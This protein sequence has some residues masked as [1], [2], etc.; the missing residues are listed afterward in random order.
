MTVDMQHAGERVQG[1]AAEAAGSASVLAYLRAVVAASERLV[2]ETG[3][4]RGVDAALEALRLDTGLDRVYVFRDAPGSDGMFIYSE[5]SHPRVPGIQALFGDRHFPDDQYPEVS[6]PLRAGRI[7]QSVHTQRH[8][9][10]A[11]YNEAL[12]SRSDLMVPIVV[13]GR[14]WGAIGF[15]DCRSD[16]VWNPSEIA[17]LQGAASAIAAAVL[18]D[19]ADRAQARTAADLAMRDRLLAAVALALQALLGSDDGHFADA[20]HAT[21]AALGAACGIHRIKVILQRPA[22]EDGEPTHFLDHE[23]WSAGMASQT[24]LGLT[25][26]PNTLVAEWVAILQRGEASWYL[27]EDVPMAVRAA[28]ARVGVRSVGSVPVFGGGQYL[29]L[30]AFDDCVHRRVWSDAEID[31]LTAAARTIGSAIH[32]HSLQQAMLAERDR[33]VEVEQARAEESAR[34]ALRSGRHADLLAAV[35]SAAADLLAEREPGACLDAVLARI[36]QVTQAERA[37]VARLDWTP[38]D[39]CLLGWQ[40]IAHEWARPGSRRQM[41]SDLRR[42]AMQRSDGTWERGLTQFATESRILVKIGDQDEPFRSQQ[43]A[44]GIVWS[45][46]YPI[47]V[48]G[49]VW[50]LLGFDYATSFGEYDEADLAALQTVASNIAAALLRQQLERRA[51]DAVRARAEELARLAERVDRHAQLLAAVAASAEDLL[52]AREPWTCMDAILARLSDKSGAHRAALNRFDWTPDDPELLGWQEVVHEWVLPGETRQMD[53][54]MWRFAMRRD[55]PIYDRFEKEFRATGRIV[56]N[57]AEQEDGYRSEQQGLGVVWS[58]GVPFFVD[59]VIWGA[60]G[61][62]YA[63]PYVR[64][65]EAEISALQT[66]AS[67]IADALIRQRLEARTLAVERQRGDDNARHAG[68]LA[69]VVQSSRSLIDAEPQAFEPALLRWLGTFGEETRAS[70][71]TFYDLVTYEATGQRTARMLCEWVR[72]GVTG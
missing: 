9:A 60:L 72:E 3:L 56:V 46:S 40:E 68:L 31:A 64:H 6:Q 26:F 59:G 18:R 35:A 5:S 49:Q 12:S 42:F 14:F 55:E 39:P 25:R 10:N 7:Y 69:K 52:A 58:L 13:E 41:D 43:T 62:D 53:T 38:D 8:G 48:G 17:A 44:L 21:L 54:P 11:A 71:A 33:R 24:S 57:I 50:G 45:L 63:T 1:V 34:H 37:C 23:W 22:P 65:D 15:D 28:F 51:L 20:V 32:K 36:G 19:A 67:S 4:Q 16:H 66:V 47:L 70:R 29:G 2:A 30:I 27:I 61:F